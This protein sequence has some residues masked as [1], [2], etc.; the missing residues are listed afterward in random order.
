MNVASSGT[1][2]VYQTAPLTPPVRISG[3]PYMNL[4]M[5]FSKAEGE[6]DR[7]PGRY[8]AAGGN[9]TILSRGWLDPENRKSDRVASR[10]CPASSTTCASTCS[11]RTWS[12]RPAAGSGS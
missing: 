11:R 2:L 3:T 10:S 8:P 1:R 6:P 4:R 7:H 9:G 5:S 12:S